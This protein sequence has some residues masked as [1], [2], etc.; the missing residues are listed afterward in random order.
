MSDSND[1]SDSQNQKLINTP[2]NLFDYPF[3]DIFTIDNIFRNI[4]S[5]GTIRDNDIILIYNTTDR[6]E[7]W[8][9]NFF[10]I[11]V[12]NDTYPSCINRNINIDYDS[13]I[14]DENFLTNN[15]IKNKIFLSK[16]LECTMIKTHQKSLSIRISKVICTINF[17]DDYEF[18]LKLVKFDTTFF[19]H[20]PK[21]F[22]GYNIEITD[23]CLINDDK[24]KKLY[25]LFMISYK[26]DKDA[27]NYIP[28]CF[29]D[30]YVN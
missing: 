13:L 4:Y 19:K 12:L 25:E 24:L 14:S 11:K 20:I 10:D 30:I 21:K 9:L 26:N 23:N 17:D 2:L 28:K 29:A 16:L 8:L 18:V 22:R 7:Q 3:N 15:H 1:N 6:Y 5:D 27:K